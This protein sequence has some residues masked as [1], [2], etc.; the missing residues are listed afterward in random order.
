M[1]WVVFAVRVLLGLS[2]TFTG[3]SYFLMPP[4]EPPTQENALKFITALGASDYMKVV[5]VLE[6][7]GGIL[8]LTGRLAPLGLVLLVPITFNIALW[9]IFLVKFAVPPAGLILL[10]LELFVMWGYWPYFAPFFRADAKLAGSTTST[11]RN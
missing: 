10:A 11:S 6:L 3:A 7:L 9:D 1:I 8:L 5:K 2:F 4:M